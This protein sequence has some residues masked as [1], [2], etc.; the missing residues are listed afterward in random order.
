MFFLFALASVILFNF[1]TPTRA[2]EIQSAS[3]KVTVV[4]AKF[5]LWGKVG[6]TISQTIKI[7]NE[8]SEDAIIAL[9]VQGLG[10]TGENG[11]VTLD[12]NYLAKPGQLAKWIEFDQK[13]ALYAAKET[14][15]IN[16]KINIPN[17][18]KPGGQYASIVVGMDRVNR[19]AKEPG[20]SAKVVSLLMLDVAGDYTESANVVSFKA[21]KNP[22]KVYDFILRA[23]NRGNSHIKPKGSIIITNI[24]GTK[25]A[26]VELNSENVLPQVVRKITTSWHPQKTL[27]GWYT[28]TLISNYGEK[29]D[30][31]LTAATGFYVMPVW[32]S[33]IIILIAAFIAFFIGRTIRMLRTRKQ[34][35]N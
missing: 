2:E 3:D 7:T 30:M 13:S 24:W 17:E 6:E 27:A 26:E 16:F 1:A 34:A 12:E 29:N 23:E 35:H 25:V 15:I 4:P 20:A 21:V 10:V 11:E 19:K 22:K 28:A 33:T 14:K 32:F 31:P 5:E 9:S 8:D 18:L